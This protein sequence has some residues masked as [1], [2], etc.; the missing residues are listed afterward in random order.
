VRGRERGRE[1]RR[2]ERR[3]EGREGGRKGGTDRLPSL[4]VSQ[5]D[6]VG[7]LEGLL[8]TMAN[9]FALRLVH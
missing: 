4:L 9:Y 8:G 6:R 2:K 1:E 5:A 7:S 3:K